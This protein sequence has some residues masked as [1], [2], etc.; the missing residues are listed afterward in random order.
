MARQSV[1]ETPRERVQ[2]YRSRR[3]LAAWTLLTVAIATY[4]YTSVT[5]FTVLPAHIGP[6]LGITLTPLSLGALLGLLGWGGLAAWSRRPLYAS[7]IAVFAGIAAL[8]IDFGCAAVG[9]VGTERLHVFLDWTLLGPAISA[10]Y[11]AGQCAYICP[12]SVEL[13][14]LLVGYVL[15]AELCISVE[16]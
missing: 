13:L 15:L 5:W 2:R 1:S 10:A 8:S 6:V 12:H 3:V 14:P 7:G 11:D 4:V 9:C 16:H